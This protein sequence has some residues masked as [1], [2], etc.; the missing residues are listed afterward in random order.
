MN[1]RSLGRTGLQVSQLSQGGA[2]FGEQY[3]KVSETEVHACV[4]RA[5]DAGINLF[6]TSP[7]YGLTRAETVLGNALE[8]GLRQKVYLCTK[9]GRNGARDFD[10]SAT[11]M[12]RSVEAS[13]VRLKTDYLDLLIA[14]DIEFADDFERVFTE[15]AEVLHRLKE[16]GKCRFIGMSGYPLGILREAIRRCNLDVV[17]S[18]G[19][20][21]L[22]TS[23]LLSELLPVADQFGVGVLNASP[24]ALGLLTQQGPPEWHPAS[25]QMKQLARKAAEHCRNRGSDLASLGMQFC[26]SEERIPTTITGA[27]RSEELERNLQ[28]LNV[29]PDPVLLAEVLSILDPVQNQFWQ[30]GNWVEK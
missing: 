24:L 22:Q 6:D 28:T 25:E 12:R 16:E 21:T 29:T 30:S 27:A 2:A 20:F 8:G 1:Y 9:A 4:R 5:I 14:H 7:Y 26:L 10:F 15:T 11:A 18:Y 23:R 13:L 3:G 17:I 19:H